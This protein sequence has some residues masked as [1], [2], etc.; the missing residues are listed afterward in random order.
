MKT[1]STYGNLAFSTYIN[2]HDGTCGV[3]AMFI[4]FNYSCIC[5]RVLC[6]SIAI[7]YYD[8]CLAHCY[9]KTAAS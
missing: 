9:I 3:H 8:L 7:S 6:V 1:S 5:Q 2:K 4:Q